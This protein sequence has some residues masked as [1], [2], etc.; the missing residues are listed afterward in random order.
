MNC[1]SCHWK[2]LLDFRCSCHCSIQDIKLVL[3]TLNV[4][5]LLLVLHIFSMQSGHS[6]LVG[7]VCTNPRCRKTNSSVH[8]Y[9]QHRRS[10]ASRGTLCANIACMGEIVVDT[11]RNV[12][13]AIL[14]REDPPPMQGT[15]GDYF[16]VFCVTG[17]KYSKVCKNIDPPKKQIGTPENRFCGVPI[18]LV[19]FLVTGQKYAK[20]LQSHYSD[21]RVNTL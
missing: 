5:H 1:F 4:L 18:F 21:Y 14:R 3:H 12:A 9:K 17:P 6:R 15:F 2:H 13:T 20:F 19:R 8:A 16:W 11:R 7:I 10:P